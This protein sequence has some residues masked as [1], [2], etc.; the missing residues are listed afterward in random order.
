M[1]IAVRAA[2]RPGPRRLVYLCAILAG[3][4]AGLVIGLSAGVPGR[5]PADARVVTLTPIWMLWMPL[6]P[7]DRAGDAFAATWRFLPTGLAEALRRW[8]SMVVQWQEPKGQCDRTRWR[9]IGMVPL[10]RARC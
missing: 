8:G 6:C 9:A 7:W 5:I 4:A 10:N 2:A 1:D 3:V